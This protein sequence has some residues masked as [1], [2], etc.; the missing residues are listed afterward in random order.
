VGVGAIAAEGDRRPDTWCRREAAAR[1]SYAAIMAK[2][3]IQRLVD[4]IDGSEAI[5]TISFEVEGHSY[6]IDLNE[7]HAGEVR[8]KLEPFVGV[9][10]RVRHQAGHARSNPRGGATD[11]DRNSGIRQWAFDEGVQLPTRGRIAGAVQ[12]AYD[13]RDV[14]ALYAATGLEREEV[15]A[16][17]ATRRRAAKAAFSAS[18]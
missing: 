7:H 5:E 2:Q 14:A 15:P 12:A 13:T 8:A 16:P 18:E 11:K 9:A 6:Q 17:K 1:L 10:R 3:V 4:D